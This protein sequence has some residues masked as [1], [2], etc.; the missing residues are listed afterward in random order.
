M[1]KLAEAAKAARRDLPKGPV[2]LTN[3]ATG[4][5]RTYDSADAAEAALPAG[6]AV[7][8]AKKGLGAFVVVKGAVDEKPAARAKRSP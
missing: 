5:S 8:A 7:E 2:V 6:A 1:G 4:T 3:G